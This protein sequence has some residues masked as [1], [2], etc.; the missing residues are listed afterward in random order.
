MN[1]GIRKFSNNH[2][3]VQKVENGVVVDEGNGFGHD[4]KV[5][6]HIL[7]CKMKLVFKQKKAR[8]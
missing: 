1:D 8:D 3:A 4:S 7:N 5:N 6:Q 2:L